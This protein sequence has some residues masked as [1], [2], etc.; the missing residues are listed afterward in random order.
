MRL[1][2]IGAVGTALLV[3]LVVV[4]SP[5][6]A[7]MKRFEV[8]EDFEEGFLVSL[9][10][11]TIPD[12]LQMNE[13]GTP[14]P[15]V[16]VVM[17]DRGTVVRL[18]AETGLALGEYL[19]A[20]TGFGRQPEGIA[21]DGLGNVWVANSAEFSE[22]EGIEGFRGSITRIG[23]VVGGTRTDAEGNPDPEGEYLKPPFLYSTCP[24]RDGDGLIRTSRGFLDVF[25]WESSGC[26]TSED[27]TDECI[28]AFVRPPVGLLRTLAVDRN[29]DLWTAGGKSGEHIQI[30]GIFGRPRPATLFFPPCFLPVRGSIV[31]LSGNLWTNGFGLEA[32]RRDAG[33]GDVQCLPTFNGAVGLDPITG[34]VWMTS[35]TEQEQAFLVELDSE[36]NVVN[37]YDD[38]TF[39]SASW[40]TVDSNRNVW[41][42]DFDCSLGEVYRFAPDE[43][44]PGQH[45]LLGSITIDDSGEKGMSVDANGKIWVSN[46]CGSSIS[47]IDPEAGPIVGG[48]PL[49]AV[50]LT[51]PLDGIDPGVPISLGDMT[52]FVTLNSSD[53]QKGLWSVVF[54]SEGEGTTWGTA[55]WNSFEPLG[56]RILV[57]VRATDVEA[58]L[59]REEFVPVE[60]GVPF[61]GVTGRY[62]QIQ[63]EF[64]RSPGTDS[65]V[66]FDVTIE[67]S[68]CFLLLAK[69]EGS[70]TF[71]PG[72]TGH[73]FPTHLREIR[74]VYP[75]LIENNPGIRVPLPK[76]RLFAPLKSG[77][78]NGPG[79]LRRFY[80][81]VLMWNPRVFPENP[82]QYTNGLEVTIWPGERVTARPYGDRDGME[83]TLQVLGETESHVFVRF[84]F[85]IEGL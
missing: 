63:C 13:N 4:A 17:N 41:L 53:L 18:D 56:T 55:S 32:I 5:A 81:Q 59:P 49:G 78:R 46:S 39:G 20:P 33:T 82:E 67:A 10:D 54:D 80:A 38:P 72:P 9:N 74:R 22:C 2:D 58:R 47:R 64:A 83:V 66:L 27:A 34:N 62:I 76:G 44:N 65:P 11:D 42:A 52:G 35:L 43:A 68:E 84:P 85:T 8:N 21:V 30:D 16:N 14:L 12:Q 7:Q 1:Q 28:T 40:I 37:S 70:Q 48:Q 71:R 61:T 51:V 79:P 50:D 69:A 57:S 6:G 29:G 77:A 73:E 15:F 25:P 45:R 60:N 19:T 75:V 36:G 3:M 31:D 26:G 23:L 24:D